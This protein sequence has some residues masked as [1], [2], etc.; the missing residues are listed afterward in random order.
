MFWL[1]L[2]VH[3]ITWTEESSVSY[4]FNPEVITFEELGKLFRKS[5]KVLNGHF[6]W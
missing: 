3:Y 2:F 5:M 1:K 6:L 4:C